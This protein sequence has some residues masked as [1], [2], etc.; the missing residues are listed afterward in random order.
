MFAMQSHYGLFI[1]SKKKALQWRNPGIFFNLMNECNHLKLK[2]FINLKENGSD[3]L[4][5]LKIPE[6]TCRLV[7]NS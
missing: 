1:F 2:I 3:I 4:Q 5:V 6:S 7:M